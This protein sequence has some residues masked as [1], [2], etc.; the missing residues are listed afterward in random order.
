MDDYEIAAPDIVGA[1]TEKVWEPKAKE[2]TPDPPPV[3]EYKLR[4]PLEFAPGG[5]MARGVQWRR[6][7]GE[8]A[9]QKPLRER[10]AERKAQTQTR[11]V[12]R[13]AKLKGLAERR[14]ERAAQGHGERGR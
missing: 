1:F 2:K 13:E 10:V 4:P 8:R 9:Q 3:P 5:S 12:F 7:A 6:P 14:F 11:E